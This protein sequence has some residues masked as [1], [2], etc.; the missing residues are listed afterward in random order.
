MHAQLWGIVLSAFV[1]AQM[2]HIY[3][4]VLQKKVSHGVCA[5]PGIGRAHRFARLSDCPCV[6][7]SEPNG[8]VEQQPWGL[9][10]PYGHQ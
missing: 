4:G 8:A 3:V 5:A 1:V 9:D 6:G 10:P 7:W 2:L